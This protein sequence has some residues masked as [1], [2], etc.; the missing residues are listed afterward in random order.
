MIKDDYFDGNLKDKNYNFYI[1]WIKI[2]ASYTY[3]KKIQKN[4]FEVRIRYFFYPAGDSYALH[5]YKIF[6]K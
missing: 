6:L 1:F 2:R 5:S 3:T 4:L